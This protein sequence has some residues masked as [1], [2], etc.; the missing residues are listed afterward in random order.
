MIF[1]TD[2]AIGN[3]Q[4]LF[5]VISA[6]R[7]RSRIFMVGIGSAPN[8]YLMNRAAELGR[9]TF[10]HI[11]STQQ[12]EE[13]TRALFEKLESPVVTNL[14]AT[15][16]AGEADMT[17]RILPDL[18]RGE[19]LVLAARLTK[20]DGTVE[21]RGMV[22]DRPW[23]VTL[24]LARAAEGKGLSKL[25][26]RR[27][28]DDA[29][30][31]LTLGQSTAEEADRVVLRLALEHH[32]V[33]RLTSLV[34]VEDSPSRPNGE[35]LTRAD[36]PLNLPAGWDFEKVFGSGGDRSGDT[37]P[38]E[39]I[40]AAQRR[41]SADAAV[42]LAEAAL[43]GVAQLAAPAPAKARSRNV[44]VPLPQ[45]ATD[46]E[47]RLWIGLALLA[48]SLLLWNLGLLKGRRLA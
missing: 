22:G 9:G 29:E 26:A 13:R 16:S 32:L 38:A 6:G 27:K 7:G 4:Q 44:S 5:D 1:L 14:T 25:W 18:Y 47:I 24:P 28:I 8:S 39:A 33:T 35:A 12:V 23:I 34:A 11:G 15:F 41:A 3:E 36:L 17:P 19:P 43:P 21:V 37:G 42:Q 20:L 40:P 10:T 46:A 2:G 48:A 30:V 45:T 31:A